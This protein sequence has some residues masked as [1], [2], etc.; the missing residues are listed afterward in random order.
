MRDSSLSEHNITVFIKVCHTTM[1]NK[2][3]N[4]KHA[5]SCIEDL[6]LLINV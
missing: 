3:D 5:C 1:S 6:Q 2:Q 4:S